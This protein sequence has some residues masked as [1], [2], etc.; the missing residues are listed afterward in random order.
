MQYPQ[1]VK[2]RWK[3]INNLLH[4]S[5][6][7][8]SYFTGLT[9]N[10]L[11]SYFTDKIRKI[12]LSITANLIGVL[13]LSVFCYPA[14]VMLDV[15]PPVTV[16][17][18]LEAIKS[19]QKPSPLDIIPLHILKSCSPV[20]AVLLSRLSNITF[21]TGI[22][23]RHFK[24]AEVRPLLKKPDLDPTDPVSYRPISNLNSL[25][26]LL[27]KFV[28][29]RLSKHVLKSQ[30]FS[31]IQSGYR[32]FHPTETATVKILNDLIV[33]T[34]TGCPSMMVSLDLSSAF[35]CVIHSK[36]LNRLQ[37]EFGVRG[38]CLDWLRSYLKD[39]SQY[40]SMKDV[41]SEITSLKT[42]VARC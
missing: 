25:G 28:Q 14:N 15:F 6:H 35:D 23:P 33:N 19:L 12:Q 37:E 18:A 38:R 20:F 5:K 16:A 32:P 4:V 17:E 42:G 27:E 1:H 9:A 40:V 34:T 29:S 22:F 8:V 13:N 31:E 2:D 26:K 10:D 3:I 39:R 36:L 21:E 11:C 41:K 7:S 30:N 24:T